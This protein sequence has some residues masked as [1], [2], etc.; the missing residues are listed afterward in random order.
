[1][2]RRDNYRMNAAYLIGHMSGT[3]I[4]TRITIESL[5][6]SMS[7]KNW[8]RRRL[9]E[10]LSDLNESHTKHEAACKRLYTDSVEDFMD[11][12]KGK[13]EIKAVV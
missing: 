13:S 3:M 7:E 4:N 12:V 10:L 1:M 9:I 6:E 8:Q 2:E 11:F 5:I